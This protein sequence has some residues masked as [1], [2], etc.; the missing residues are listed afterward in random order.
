MTQGEEIHGSSNLSRHRHRIKKSP[1]NQYGKR[2]VHQ[3]RFVTMDKW[4]NWLW[5]EQHQGKAWTMLLDQTNL[6]PPNEQNQRQKWN[7]FVSQ[8][9]PVEDSHKW[10]KPHYGLGG[11]KW[12]T[13]GSCAD[14][15]ITRKK[16]GSMQNCG[17]QA[18]GGMHHSYRNYRMCLGTCGTL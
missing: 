6:I 4:S 11:I 8:T 7:F 10:P 5:Q 3:Q 2:F 12:W 13:D 9:R 16:S 15:M 1:R 14:G 18:C 17:N